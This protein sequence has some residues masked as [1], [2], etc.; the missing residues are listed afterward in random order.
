MRRETPTGRR[1]HKPTGF[2]LMEVAVSAALVA[3][4]AAATIPSLNEFVRGREAM[5]TATTLSQL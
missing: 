2:T 4:L 1:R 5:S 3:I